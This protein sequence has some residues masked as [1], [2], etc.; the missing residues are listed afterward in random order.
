MS[1]IEN[2][3]SEEFKEELAEIVKD[4]NE[5]VKDFTKPPVQNLA[6]AAEECTKDDPNYL[7]IAML[8][9]IAGITIAVPSITIWVSTHS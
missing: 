8:I 3:P 4:P 1:K 5:I 7:K 6:D 9:V 2:T